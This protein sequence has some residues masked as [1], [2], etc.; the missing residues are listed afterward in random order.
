MLPRLIQGGM[1]AGVS[2]WVLAREVSSL[3]QLGVVSGTALDSILVRKL[4]DGDPDGHLRRAIAAFPSQ[5]IAR[6]V[7]DRYLR[8]DGSV[9]GAAPSARD[10]D[11]D[12]DGDEAGD[13]AGELSQGRRYKLAPLLRAPLT[14]E[15]QGLLVLANFV[16]VFLAKEGH[17]GVVGIN[18]LEKIQL[19]TLPSL[20]GAM[21]ANVDVVLMGAGIPAE[22]PGALDRLSRHLDT[23]ISL[24]VLNSGDQ[25]FELRFD[26][27]SIGLGDGAVE[28]RRPKFLPIV[29]AATLAKALLRKSPGGIDGFVVEGPI[30]G[31]HNA[32]P[33]GQLHL[34]ERGEPVYGE[35]DVVDL[36][37]MKALGVPFWLAGAY[38]SRERFAEAVAAGAHG[39]Q[40]GTAFAFCEE[41]GLDPELRRRF[42]ANLVL[43]KGDVFTDPVA[44]PT[45]FPFKVAVLEGTLSDE[46]PYEERPRLCDLGYLRRA[47]VRA[48]GRLDYRCPSEPVNDYVRKGGREED[49]V[50]RKCLCNA[51]VT[52]IGMGQRRPDGYEELALLTSGDD[53]ACVRAYITPERLVYHARDVVESLLPAGTL[54][55]AA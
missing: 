14:P 39:V 45:G 50:G 44:S 3:G 41:S 4:W 49:T 15:R 11:G 30:A 23:S 25:K 43:G 51:L 40:V 5:E 12:D 17:D 53:I 29:S 42:L 54:L 13:E 34:S 19:P 10:D 46:A 16:E 24:D 32:P 36:E 47:Y 7:L 52:N 20:Y 33:R 21:L 37:Q 26:P 48:D 31:G 18:Y 38:G 8:V 6:S 2:G 9:M 55:P 35:R 27:R 1:G 28:L 22:I